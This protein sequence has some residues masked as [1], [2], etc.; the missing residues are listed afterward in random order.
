MLVFCCQAYWDVPDLLFA[1]LKI[2]IDEKLLCCIFNPIKLLN[3]KL[4][5]VSPESVSWIWDSYILTLINCW[6]LNLKPVS[7][8]STMWTSGSDI[9]M[10]INLT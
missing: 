6:K 7:A 4:K 1:D 2:Y 10:L 8:E 5:S 3:A 9:L